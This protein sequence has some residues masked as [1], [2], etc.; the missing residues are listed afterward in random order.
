MTHKK[1]T[2]PVTIDQRR[3][4]IKKI[5][6]ALTRLEAKANQ[7]QTTINGIKAE[8]RKLLFLLHDKRKGLTDAE[9]MATTNADVPKKKSTA[10]GD[11]AGND[12]TIQ[13]PRNDSGRDAPGNSAP[14]TDAASKNERSVV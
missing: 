4:Q 13:D 8:Y 7:H 6:Q 9:T 10:C 12:K 1:K 2:K 11:V 3:G 14:K 5:E